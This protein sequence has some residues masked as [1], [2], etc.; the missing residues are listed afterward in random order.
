MNTSSEHRYPAHTQEWDIILLIYDDNVLRCKLQM[1]VNALGSNSWTDITRK[2]FEIF[3]PHLSTWHHCSWPNLP[4]LPPPYLHTASNQRLVV[5]MAW[6]WGYRSRPSTEALLI[7]K[8]FSQ[9]FSVVR[10]VNFISQV[11]LHSVQCHCFL[12]QCQHFQCH[13][14]VSNHCINCLEFVFPGIHWS[15]HGRAASPSNNK[16]PWIQTDSSPTP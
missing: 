9:S 4:D 11:A 14:F 7:W 10:K 12:F 8:I 13:A 16:Q 1:Y 3:P 15:G 2:G 6:E 5:G